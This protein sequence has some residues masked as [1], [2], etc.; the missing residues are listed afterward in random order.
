MSHNISRTS[1]EGLKKPALRGAG[2]G[3]IVENLKQRLVEVS[4]A[5]QARHGLTLKEAREHAL[6]ILLHGGRDNE[7]VPR[8]P[9]ADIAIRQGGPPWERL[10]TAAAGFG[11]SRRTLERW[12]KHGCAVTLPS[13]HVSSVRL[14]TRP[15]YGRG[16]PGVLV[17]L[18]QVQF[19]LQARSQLK[20]PGRQLP[21]VRG[22]LA[23]M[24]GP[25]TPQAA[26]DMWRC[27][28]ALI[29]LRGVTDPDML[30]RL[31]IQIG[32]LKRRRRA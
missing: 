2:G 11:I 19:L 28:R 4:R 16:K 13:G 5:L 27:Q 32:L 22:N 8:V 1:P 26:R 31:Q 20:A 3:V 21:L 23:A 14:R 17:S 15:L 6:S 25:I 24:P 10:A 18:P 29:L 12:A 30:D 7:P 9:R